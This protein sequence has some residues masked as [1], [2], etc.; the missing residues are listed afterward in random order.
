M[1]DF[2]FYNTMIAF[3]LYYTMIDFHAD[4]YIFNGG[5]QIK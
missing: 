1:I 4:A 2:N 5:V 3:N